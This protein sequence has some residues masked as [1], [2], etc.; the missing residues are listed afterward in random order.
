VKNFLR[1]IFPKKREINIHEEEK[2]QSPFKSK[3][4]LFF[5]RKLTIAGM[6]IFFTILISSIFAPFWA[7][8]DREWTDSTQHNI[9]PGFFFMRYPR[10]LSGNVSNI[11]AGNNFAV[12][13]DNDGGFHIWGNIEGFRNHHLDQVPENMGYVTQVSSGFNHVLVL[14]AEGNVFSWGLDSFGLQDIPQGVIDN[15]ITY[16]HAGRQISIAMDEF[17]QVYVWGNENIVNI[18][19]GAI[20]GEDVRKI[21]TTTSS[22][23]ALLADGTIVSLTNRDLNINRFPDN[24]DQLQGRFVDMAITRMSGAGVLDDGT[25]VVW[26]SEEFGLLDVPPHIQ[27][28]VVSIESGQD[29]FTVLLNDGTVE[30]WGFDM[31]GQANAPNVSGIVAIHIG[32][33]QN[34]AVDGDGE[35]HTW[36]LSGYLLGT[37]GHGRCVFRR[38]VASGRISLTIGAVA[39]LIANFLGIL[40]GSISG[41]YSGKVDVFLMRLAEVWGAIPSLPTL[42]IISGLIGNRLPEGARVFMLMS[43]IGILGW[44]SMARQV[45]AQMLEARGQEYVAA[46]KALGVATRKIIFSHIFPN[47]IALVAVRFSLSLANS[48]LTEASLSFLGL[49]IREPTATWGSMLNASMDSTVIRDFWWRWLPPAVFLSFSTISLHIMG[50]GLREAFDPKI[51]GKG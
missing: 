44:P 32:Y 23:L 9:R 29:H 36:G 49:G 12:G 38:L 14:N 1:K 19:A 24:F 2:I 40:I 31:H 16:I 4:K 5:T 17:N 43:I 42:I 22:G 34:Y 26:G 45:R 15:R 27:G 35:I 46:A 13:I 3:M 25:V 7:P 37:D 21:E 48:L 33:Y 51:A 41:Y 10:A 50:D 39:T 20:R 30:S 18:R 8:L 6:I 47:I 28:N 11:S